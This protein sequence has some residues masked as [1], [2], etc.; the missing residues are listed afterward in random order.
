MKKL[1]LSPHIRRQLE[2]VVAHSSDARQLRR[3]QAVL[4]V[5]DGVRVVTVAQRLRTTC[6]SV[7]N[8]IDRIAQ[9]EG[10]VEHRLEDAPRSGRPSDKRQLA[11]KVIPGLLAISPQEKGYRS[12]G[13]TRRL[14][15]D[16]LQQH[17]HVEVSRHI[18]QGAVKRAGYRWKRPRY[19]L[20]RRAQHWRQS[21]GGSSAV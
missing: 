8:W 17:H 12:T 21:K 2:E 6:Q 7:Y 19:V 1:K 5:N 13:W 18:V 15:I 14:L 11:D 10:S 16:Y 9:G 4:W 20:S 3:A